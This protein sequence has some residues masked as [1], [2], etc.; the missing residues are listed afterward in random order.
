MLLLTF[1][2]VCLKMLDFVFYY[3][4]FVAIDTAF[5]LEK[6]AKATVFSRKE[7]CWF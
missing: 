4:Q 2:E 1:L 7:I 5:L 6:E 3:T